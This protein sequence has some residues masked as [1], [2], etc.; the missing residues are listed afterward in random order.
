MPARHN[1]GTVSDIPVENITP[2]MVRVWDHGGASV[3]CDVDQDS[4]HYLVSYRSTTPGEDG[5]REPVTVEVPVTSSLPIVVASIAE[6]E[7]VEPSSAA[8]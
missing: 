2:G 7:P 5:S 3:V 8:S 6:P 1:N 4:A